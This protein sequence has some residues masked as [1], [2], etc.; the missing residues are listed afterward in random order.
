MPT[1]SKLLDYM[2]KKNGSDLY[3]SAGNDIFARIDGDLR[4]ISHN[5][6]SNKDI[7][8]ILQKIS[9]ENKFKEYKETLE[10]DF[11][12]NHGENYRFRVNAFHNN[13]GPAIVF[14]IIPNDSMSLKQLDVPESIHDLCTLSKGLVLVVGPTGSGKSTTLAAMINEMN[15]KFNHHILT[16]E[17]PVEFTFK[18]KNSLINQRQVGES[19]PS[20]ASALKNALRE[21]PDVIMVGEMR[22]VETT[23]LALTAAE[24][25]HLVL[26]TL[27]TMSAAQTI[28]R[29]IDIFPSSEKNIARSMLS[30]S[31]QAVISQRL[32][33]KKEGGRCA[34]FEIMIANNSIKNLIR[35]DKI[36]QINS[37][38]EL[39]QKQ[40]MVS[41]KDSLEILVAKNHISQEDMDNFMLSTN[42]NH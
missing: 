19:T 16:I 36:P 29:I 11:S 17:D 42:S 32:L 35:E 40:G 22:D 33:K 20:F 15:E 23:K 2:V 10:A 24:T 21:S 18:T 4:C 38:I 1:I 41:M 37:A 12:I 31:I 3:I 7:Y 28:N 13:Y 26:A 8:D 9:T 25:G 30:S 6:L 34:A 27:H 5:K 39:G 14:R